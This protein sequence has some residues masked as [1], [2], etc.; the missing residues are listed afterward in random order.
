MT[1][2]SSPPLMGT[3]KFKE[4]VDFQKILNES[5]NVFFRDA[6]RVALTNPLQ[7]YHFVRTVR[8][9]RKASHIRSSWKQKGIHVP[10]ILIF[11]ITNRCNLHC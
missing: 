5:L 9:Q 10:P 1:A 8:W 2:N 7:A 6:L 3:V 4:G 11:S